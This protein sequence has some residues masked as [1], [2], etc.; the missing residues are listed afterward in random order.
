[1]KRDLAIRALDMAAALRRLP[2]GCTYH[3]H[4]GSQYCSG[5]YHKRLKQYGFLVS[6]SGKGN[7]CDNSLSAI[8]LRKSPV[9]QGMVKTFFKSL[10][11]ELIWR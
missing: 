8:L 6:M 2:K 11:A 5:D 4:R 3:T 9:G 7:C 10:K 1:M